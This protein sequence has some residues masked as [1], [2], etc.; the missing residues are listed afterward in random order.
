[1]AFSAIALPPVSLANYE[2]FLAQP[3]KLHGVILYHIPSLGQSEVLKLSK[4]RKTNYLSPSD[5]F[6]RE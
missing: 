2:P 3:A 5:T 4:T 6:Q 1:L